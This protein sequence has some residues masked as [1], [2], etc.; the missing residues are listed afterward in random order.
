MKNKQTRQS[1]GGVSYQ[2]KQNSKPL[3][4]GTET[5]QTQRFNTIS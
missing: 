2:I 3:V 1:V 5:P 4:L